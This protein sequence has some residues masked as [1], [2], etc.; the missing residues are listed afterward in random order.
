MAYDV[1]EAARLLGVHRNTI[2]RWLKDGLEPI[3]DRRPLLIHGSR[4]KAFLSQRMR[5]RKRTCRPGEFYCFRC[6]APRKPWGGMADVTLR[7]EKLASLRALCAA[8]ET[9]MYRAIRVAD[10][11]CLRALIDL[12]TMEPERLNDRPSPT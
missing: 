11:P 5:S 9:P 12:Q 2:R 1:A 6:R 4:L 10:L 8:C 3:D 7:T